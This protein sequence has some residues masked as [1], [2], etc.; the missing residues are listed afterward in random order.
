MSYRRCTSQIIFFL[1]VLSICA[2]AGCTSNVPPPSNSPTETGSQ[3]P[4]EVAT[5]NGRSISSKLYEMYLKNGQETIGFDLNTDEGRRRLDLL[6]EGIVSELI[7]RTL[8]AEEAERRGLAIPAEKLAEAERRAITELGG[9][10]RYDTYLAGHRLTRDEYREVVRVQVYGEMMRVELNKGLSI[11]DEEVQTDYKAHL[12][13][14]ALQQAERVKA[15]HILVAARPNLISQQLQ[16]EKSLNTAALSEAVNEEMKQRRERAE[17][18]R[19]RAAA[20]ADFGALARQSSEDPSTRDRGGDLGTFARDSHARA[21]DD[22][23]FA[24]KPG[25]VSP[26]IQTE[27]GFHVIKVTAREPARTRSLGEASPEI[28]RRLLA[29]REAKNL[30]DWLKEARRKAVVRLNEP[31]RI[32]ALK[33]EFP[34]R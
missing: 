5:V 4:P 15:A 18:L 16:Q 6:R 8:I 34:P 33:D 3:L 9:D 7:D 2:V 19:R 10:E 12:S 25:E 20:G 24:L 27:F 30:T 13:D 28:R 11:S 17:A 21:F 1:T 26:V 22:A 32:G 31:F 23:A 29:E 14:Q